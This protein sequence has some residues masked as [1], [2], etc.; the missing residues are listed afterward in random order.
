MPYAIK[1]DCS[2]FAI[3]PKGMAY[4]LSASKL[5]LFSTCP[6]AYYFKYER[7]L[8]DKAMFAQPE[9]GIALHKALE[10]FYKDW[11]YQD[12]IPPRSRILESWDRV[13]RDLKPENVSEGFNRLNLYFDRFIK[14]PGIMRKPLGIEQ[15]IK[16]KV[17][18][19][20]I[21]FEL[22]GRYD[23]LDMEDGR[24]SL[25]DYKGGAAPRQSVDLDLQSGFYD[26]ILE[27]IY[28]KS[29][30]EWQIIY[31]KTG[32]K[33][34]YLV[35]EEHRSRVRE[36]IGNLAKAIA[37]EEQWIPCESETCKNAP[38]NPIALPGIRNRR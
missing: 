29:L 38:T 31:L 21:E 13:S 16:R 19:H 6:Q 33:V 7:K 2:K 12:L 3:Y 32:E 18:I 11:H 14:Q 9:L 35:T 10:N 8:P 30:G 24:L 15:S 17:V 28:E 4:R 26:W 22:R 27:G 23:R 5:T 20:G 36:L 34:S 1:I 37:E 25:I